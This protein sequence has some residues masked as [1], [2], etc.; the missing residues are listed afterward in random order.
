MKRPAYF[1]TSQGTD[2]SRT[3]VFSWCIPLCFLQMKKQTQNPISTA[4]IVVNN[5]ILNSLRQH[6]HFIT[7]GIYIG[8]M[9]RL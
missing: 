7:Q 8:Y 6:N 1:P 2:P 9:F 3:F 5:I 4:I